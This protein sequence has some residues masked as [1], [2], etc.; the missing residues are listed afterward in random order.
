ML[1]IKQ[2]IGDT[3]RIGNDIEIYI[4]WTGRYHGTGGVIMGITAPKEL[5][6]I[7][8]GMKKAKQTKGR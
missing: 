4:A 2:N 5:D 7:R 6:I 3:V 8:D 1:L